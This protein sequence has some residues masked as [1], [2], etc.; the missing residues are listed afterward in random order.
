MSRLLRIGVT[1]LLFGLLFLIRA[2]ETDL[3]YDPLIEYFQ[4]DYLYR[5]I[6]EINHWKLIVDMLFRYVMN[7]LITL[8]IIY[9]IF[10]QKSYL[11][12]SGFLLMISFM[13]MIVIF[14]MLLRTKFES[15]YLF[16]FYIRR[17]MVHPIFLLILLPAFFYH[18]RAIRE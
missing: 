8:G 15:G 16:P 7:S 12:F 1:F 2:F 6:P 3:F 13:L 11:K 4:N 17:F 5:S 18:K 10:W 9:M 14:S